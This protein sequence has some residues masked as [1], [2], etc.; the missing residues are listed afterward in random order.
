[1]PLPLVCLLLLLLLQAPSFAGQSAEKGLSKNWANGPVSIVLSEAEKKTWSQLRTDAE[2]QAFADQFWASRDPNPETRINEYRD[3]FERR[4]EGANTLFG[5]ESAGEG[6]RSERG[7][8]YVLLG[9]PASR[10]QFKGYGQLRPIELWF[11]S[12]KTEYPQLPAF[13]YLMF[14]QRDEIGDYRRYSPFIDQPQS[15]VKATIRSNADAYNIL[16]GINSDLARA[17][18]SLIPSEP[19]DTTGFIPTMSSDAVLAQ[20]NQIPRR[21]FERIGTLRELVDVKLKFGAG[22]TTMSAYSFRSGA[23]T[24]IVD[25]AIDRPEGIRQASVKTVVT[26]EGDGSGQPAAVSGVFAEDEPL[27]GRLI[28]T[29]GDYRIEAA[30][31]DSQGRQSYIAHDVIHLKAAP[32]TLSLGD[33]LFFRTAAATTSETPFVHGGYRFE[34]EIRRQFHPADKFQVLFQIAAAPAGDARSAQMSI[35]YTIAAVNNAAHRWTF[36]DQI[37]MDRF[38][39]NGLLLNSKTLSLREIPPGRYFLVIVATDPAGHRASQTVSFQISEASASVARSPE[40]FL[41]R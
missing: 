18:L 3:E 38:D 29:A 24:F 17:S 19:V 5:G 41:R 23:D 39:K 33:V 10:A 20:I 26:R 21:D 28:L 14:Y 11:Y 34:P 40:H 27:V 2:R 25:I 32:A 7:R 9:A 35:D 30:V 13:F 12:G 36:H 1:M 8:F 31:S 6:W 37:G 4:V 16:N 22:T 15:L